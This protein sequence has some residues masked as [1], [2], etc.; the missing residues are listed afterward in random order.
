MNAPQ[1]SFEIQ[2]DPD[3][4]VSEL[5]MDECRRLVLMTPEM[6]KGSQWRPMA[7]RYY[8]DG[9]TESEIASE[10]V[11]STSR[12]AQIVR[13]YIDGCWLRLG[14]KYRRRQ[15]EVEHEQMVLE[16]TRAVL[17]KRA[18][19]YRYLQDC[20]HVIVR[21]PFTPYHLGAGQPVTNTSQVG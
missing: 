11:V 1:E 8:V 20:L 17:E 15:A 14:D 7:V 19:H 4:E 6:G 13:K 18:Q 2:Y 10:M 21:K 5:S 9:L 12:V 3:R 16:H